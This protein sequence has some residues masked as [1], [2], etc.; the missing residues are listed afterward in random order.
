MIL[1]YNLENIRKAVGV[2]M[3]S[4]NMRR[5]HWALMGYYLIVKS[6]NYLKFKTM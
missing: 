6:N 2:L 3:I 1:S 4:R 5:K